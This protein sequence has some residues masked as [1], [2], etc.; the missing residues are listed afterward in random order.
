MEIFEYTLVR[1]DHASNNKRGSVCVYYNSF[2]HLRMLNVRYLLESTCFELKNGDKTCNFLSFYRFLSHSQGFHYLEN[3]AQKNPFLV[4]AIG[5]C[6][7]KSS[8]WY[9]QD[10]TSFEGDAIENFTSQFGWHHWSTMA[11]ELTHTLD[12][13]SLCIDLIFTSQPNLIIESGVHLS[14]H[15]N[16]HHQTKFN[17][18]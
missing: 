8:N 15:S 1:S 4:V 16:C 2:L 11:K 18:I 5:D 9:C 12:T 14:L 6:N 7:V 3:L 10:K 17:R 13:S